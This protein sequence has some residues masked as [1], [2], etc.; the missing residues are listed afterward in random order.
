MTISAGSAS[1]WQRQACRRCEM[2]YKNANIFVNSCFQNGAF[3]VENGRFTQ[4]LDETPKNEDGI[5]LE[6]RFVIPG[7]VDV[8][9]HG[10]SDEDF[11]DGDYN[12]L[13][14]MAQ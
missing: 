6:N 8:H 14:K 7:L 9:N 2:L 10:N 11:S 4:I 5:D 13:V 1:Q 12:G 3:R